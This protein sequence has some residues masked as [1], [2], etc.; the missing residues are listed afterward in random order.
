MV[1]YV[2]DRSA[3]NP[4]AFSKENELCPGDSRG[5]LFKVYEQEEVERDIRISEEM[6]ELS[7]EMTIPQAA[8]SIENIHLSGS[9]LTEEPAPT[10]P[11]QPALAPPPTAAG[12][13]EAPE[14]AAATNTA[15]TAAGGKETPK[16]VAATNTAPKAAG[17]TETPKTAAAAKQGTD[18]NS[19]FAPAAKGGT[20]AP[21]KAAATNT[22]PAAAGGT[23]AGPKT[24]APGSLVAPDTAAVAIPNKIAA[25]AATL[26][27]K[28]GGKGSPG[29]QTP[30]E[31]SSHK[32]TGAGG[33]QGSGKKQKKNG[34]PNSCL[35]GGRLDEHM[36]KS[37]MRILSADVEEGKIQRDKCMETRGGKSTADALD[38]DFV[39]VQDLL[40]NIRTAFVKKDGHHIDQLMVNGRIGVQDFRNSLAQAKRVVNE[41]AAPKNNKNPA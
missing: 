37:W 21:A 1:K 9:T 13:T 38:E 3:R 16:T 29:A 31:S 36:V 17:G 39:K 2:I 33:D 25:N 8:R 40:N 4:E 35:I 19:F 20:G 10:I 5:L 28:G 18:P 34:A 30:G 14:T 15:P 12:G 24:T 27:G 26:G 6:I 23:D 7:G 11:P 22:A 41:K 32:R